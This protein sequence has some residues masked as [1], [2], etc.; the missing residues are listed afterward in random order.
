MGGGETQSIRFRKKV[1]PGIVG[2]FALD[3]VVRPDFPF[4]VATCIVLVFG[5][6]AEGILDREDMPLA[7]IL[8]GGGTVQLVG[9][10]QLVLLPHG[11]EG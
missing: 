6:A 8:P 2:P 11:K 4:Q 9:G 1:A 5:D 3:H 10:G 7:V